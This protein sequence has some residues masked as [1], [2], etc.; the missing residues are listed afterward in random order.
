MCVPCHRLQVNWN[1]GGSDSLTSTFRGRL[2]AQREFDV[3]D[4]GTAPFVNAE[5]VWQSPPASSGAASAG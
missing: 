5:F 3:G 2:E 1:L 4:V